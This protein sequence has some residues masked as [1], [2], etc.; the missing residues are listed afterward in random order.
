MAL[1]DFIRKQF[2]DVIQWTEDRDGVL[3]W[4]Y[5]MQDMEIQKG[6][7]L[8]VRESQQ[9]VFVDEGR[10]ADRFEPG[11][12]TLTTQTLPLLTNLKNWDKLFESPFK[13][14]VYFFSTRRQLDRKWGTPTPVTI[15]DAGFGMVRMRAFGIYAYHIADPLLFHRLVSGT[16][17]T[18]LADDV[19]GQLRATLVSAMT[20]GFASSGVA[21]IDMAASLEQMAAAVRPKIEEAFGS[22]GLTLDAFLIQ[23]VSLPDEI[24]KV[25]DERIGM[26]IVGDMQRYAQYQTARSMPIAAGNEGGVAGAGAGLGAGMAMASAMAHALDPA[27]AAPAPAAGPGAAAPGTPDPGAVDAEQIIATIERLHG[28]VG[29]GVL[30]QQEFDAKKT[31]LLRKLG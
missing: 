21:F 8:V 16:R 2:I 6:A 28:L 11:T 14:D 27:R 3:S 4:R 15:R 9:A 31:E 22:L 23:N 29:K 18:Y 30:S 1:M 20:Q 25:L 26:D 24:Q 13:S 19:D 10:I 17:D 12:Y 7:R 5:P